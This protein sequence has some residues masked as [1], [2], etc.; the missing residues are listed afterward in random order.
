MDDDAGNGSHAPKLIKAFTEQPTAPHLI[1]ILQLASIRGYFQCLF[2]CHEII[3]VG[4][5]TLN[6][7]TAIERN[8]HVRE[9]VS[10]YAVVMPVSADN[11]PAADV[12]RLMDVFATIIVMYRCADYPFH[13]PKIPIYNSRN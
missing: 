12:I 3:G 4:Q 11:K 13:A 1:G 7:R 2:A 10:S 5:K 9:V 8:A 6:N